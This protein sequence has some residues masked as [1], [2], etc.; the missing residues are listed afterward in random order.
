M[1]CTSCQ[2]IILTGSTFHCTLH[3]TSNATGESLLTNPQ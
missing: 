2:N 1:K 3:V